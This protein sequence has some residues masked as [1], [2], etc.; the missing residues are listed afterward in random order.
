[1]DEPGS[2]IAVELWE[3]APSRFGSV[4]VYAEARAAI[5]AARRAGRIEPRAQRRAVAGLDTTCEG[6]H[7]VGVDR[8]LSHHAGELA[9]AHSLRGYDAVHLATAL[10]IDSGLVLATWDA[11]LAHAALAVGL[12]VCPGRD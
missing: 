9:G 8:A 6:M 5:A 4:L 12:A 10:A 1:M 3:R 7:L 11:D 2:E